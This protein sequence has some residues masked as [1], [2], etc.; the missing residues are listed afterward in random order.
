MAAGAESWVLA[1]GPLVPDLDTVTRVAI[2]GGDGIYELVGCD[3]ELLSTNDVT[4]PLGVVSGGEAGRLLASSD[5][6]PAL[7]ARLLSG[8]AA[9]ACGVGAR[10]LE[11]AVTHATQRAQFGRP[12]G[13]YQAVAHALADVYVALELARSIAQWAAWSIAVGTDDAAIAAAGAK[14]T[15]ADAAVLAC[16]RSIQAHGGIGFTWEHPLQRL[17]KRALGIQSWE[18][19]SRQLRAEVADHLLGGER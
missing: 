8:L 6:L 11:L 13:A 7:R 10:A 5:E 4:R 18:A 17:Y 3:R 14:S 12:I 2:V 19:S 1:L 9:E 15:A 16:E